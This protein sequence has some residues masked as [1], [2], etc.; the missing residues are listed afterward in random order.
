MCDLGLSL[1]Q[2]AHVYPASAP[3]TDD[4]LANGIALCANHHLSFDRHQIAVLPGSLKIVF[5]PDVL[6]QAE[7]DPAVRRFIEQTHQV[8]THPR[9]AGAASDAMLDRRYQYFSDKYGW[10]NELL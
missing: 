4:S 2:G 6:S 5:H 3:G 10:L 8:L 9:R 1:V 7:D